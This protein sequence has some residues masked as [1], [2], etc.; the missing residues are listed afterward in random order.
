M[1]QTHFPPI[2][3]PDLQ[4]QALNYIN[5]LSGVY[6]IPLIECIYYNGNSIEQMRRLRDVFEI[7]ISS[8]YHSD[9]FKLFILLYQKTTKERPLPL[10]PL[11]YSPILVSF[12]LFEFLEDFDSLLEEF[13]FDEADESE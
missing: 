7:L 11:T 4:N 10:Y 9:A 5:A 12:F 2:E 3:N 8:N 6:S 1:I 13:E